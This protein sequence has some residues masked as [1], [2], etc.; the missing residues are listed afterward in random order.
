M[1]NNEAIAN[2]CDVA[3][4]FMKEHFDINEIELTDCLGNKVR[5]IHNSPSIAY[6]PQGYQYYYPIAKGVSER[7]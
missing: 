7:R 3:G 6:Y 5:L 2:L 1:M 4:E